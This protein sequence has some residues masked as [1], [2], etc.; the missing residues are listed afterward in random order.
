MGFLKVGEV[1]AFLKPLSQRPACPATPP[2]GCTSDTANAFFHL[3]LLQWVS[4][5]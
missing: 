4:Q 1:F 5:G 2:C 3:K